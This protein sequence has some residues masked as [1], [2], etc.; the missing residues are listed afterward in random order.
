MKTFEWRSIT[1]HAIAVGIFLV[2]AVIFC[3]PALEGKVLSQG[4]VIHWK[5][6]AQDMYNY[7]AKH[8][9]FPLW[10]NNLFGGMPAY[11]IALESANPVSPIY[12]HT[13]MMVLKKPI[14]YFFLLCVAFYFLSQVI[15]VRPWLGILGGIAYAYATYSPVIVAVG[16]DTKMQAM[17]YLPAF[18]AAL[19]LIYKKQYWWGAALTALFSALLIAMNHLQVTYYGLIVAGFMTVGFAIQWIKQKDYKHLATSLAIAIVAGIIGATANLVTLATTNDY[20]KATV[21]GSSL[22]LDSTGKTVRQNGLQ[23][24]RAFYYGSYGID[25]TFTFMIPR[26]YGGSSSD[27]GQ[28]LDGNS[29]LAKIAVEK[30]ISEDQAAQ[31]AGSIGTY[32]GTQPGT[33][34]PVY[35][36]AIVCFLFIFGM[37]YVKSR[38]KWW[39]FGVCLLAIMM[40]WGSN[41]S[42]FN[43]FLFNNLPF[44]NKFRAPDIILVV[45]QLLFPLLGIM[46][47]HQ[48]FNE[49]D[50][51]EAIKKLR[52]SL[53]ITGGFLLVALGLY[54]SF[55]YT[56]R[57]DEAIRNMFTQSLGGNKEEGTNFY[58]A[59]RADRKSLFG[60]DLLR[61]ILFIGASIAL[62]WLFLKNKLK[63]A[64]AMAAIIILSSIDVLSVGR[65]YLSENNFTEEE[66]MNDNAFKP[67]AVDVEILKDTSRARVLN[68]AAQGGPYNDA[69]TSYHHRSVGGYHPAK[70]S[71][72]DDL[73]S[74]QLN[75]QPLNIGVLNMMNTKYVIVPNPQ[76]GQPVLQ[77]NPG[78][79]GQ[80][81]FVKHILYVKEAGEAMKAVDNLN[82]KDT[83][84]VEEKFKKDIPF[85]P[86]ADSSAV[87]SLVNNDN[88]VIHYRTSSSTNQ[89]AVFSEVFYDRGWKAYIDDKETPIIQTNYVLRGLAIPAGNHQVRFE[90]KPASYYNSNVAAIVASA[91]IWLLL[92]GAIVFTVRKNKVTT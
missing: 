28:E 83:A 48:V 36:G 88:D 41:F 59:L 70:L 42:A 13:A 89:F 77:V 74:Y 7:K 82:P 16:H 5:G 67:S 31:F 30:G 81:W 65:K 80:A 29:H 62:L 71:I 10:N 23:I 24:D 69:I 79:L 20:A 19:W 1:P 17:G 3:K 60:A 75:K 92:I 85:Q 91:L 45:P 11:Q 43:T 66:V 35:L 34:G 56:G 44:Y 49:T 52:T 40:S 46:A 55:S 87:I 25:E 18:L 58:N 90:F 15:G 22:S 53:Y 54:L 6:M 78:A 37:V 73:I 21:R 57:N 39:I 4:D 68:L 86:V 84:V 38:H 63:M 61:S 26:I 27:V 72:Y 8:G 64:Y 76:N 51:A 50:K 33:S 47:L 14:A 12:V 32:W 9:H 2:V